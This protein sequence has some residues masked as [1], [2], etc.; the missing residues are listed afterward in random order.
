MKEFFKALGEFA[1]I[2]VCLFCVIFGYISEIFPQI[3]PDWVYYITTPV[4]IGIFVAFMA[5]LI[6]H[7][8]KKK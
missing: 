4:G 2:G 6:K 8:K 7:N 1:V 3:V 5:F